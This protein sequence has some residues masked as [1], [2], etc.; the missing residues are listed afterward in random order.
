[1]LSETKHQ[2]APIERRKAQ[3]R[4]R[5]DPSLRSATG[6]AAAALVRDTQTL[7]VAARTKK[8]DL[9]VKPGLRRLHCLNDVG[10]TYRRFTAAD[11][12]EHERVLLDRQR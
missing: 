9:H 7:V 2:L 4:G 6:N 12:K 11:Q 8:Q 3:S 5:T 1:M 10:Y